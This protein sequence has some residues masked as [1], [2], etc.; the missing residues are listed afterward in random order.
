MKFF[1]FDNAVNALRIDEAS[2]LL[3]KEFKDLW[4]IG[5]NKC[6]EDKTGK[7]RLRAMKEL[8]FIYLMLDF[9]SPY[10]QFT[11]KDKY[12]ASLVD[13]GMTE[14]D[15]KDATF[16]A[17]YKKYD[18][19]QN[20]DPILANI[21]TGI[22]VLYKMRIHLD[23][24][25]FS[26]MGPDDKPLYKPKDVINDL[27]ALEKMRDALVELEIKHKKS[28]IAQESRLRGDIETGLFDD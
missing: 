9:K 7:Q 8:T 6:K 18:E 22:N 15:T 24:I 5:R 10:Y 11:E 1:I 26:E 20:S 27:A 25:D 12:E 21:K 28:L 4:D 17:A 3:I 23:N 19:I 13:A 2:I 14:K 16:V